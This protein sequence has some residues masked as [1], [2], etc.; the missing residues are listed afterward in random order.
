MHLYYINKS[1]QAINLAFIIL[2]CSVHLVIASNSPPII[3]PISDQVGYK[4]IEV[5]IEVEDP[6]DDIISLSV[7]SSDTDV[8]PQ[9]NLLISGVG[10]IWTLI[11][12]PAQIGHSK[13]TVYAN[14]NNGNEVST[15]FN[16]QSEPIFVMPENITALPGTFSLPLT[17]N[18]PSNE[19]IYGIEFTIDYD[20]QVINAT[21]FQL[22]ETTLIQ[23][24]LMEYN[25]GISG[26][27]I[28]CM[29]S[30]SA[31]YTGAVLIGYLHFETITENKSTSLSFSNARLN[32]W[33]GLAQTGTVTVPPNQ[34]PTI[35][36]IADV[37]TD[38][39]T[40][41]SIFFTVDDPE[42][43][44][45]SVVLTIG[46][47]NTQLAPH[48]NM[49]STCNNNNY[50]L[51]IHPANNLYGTINMTITATDSHHASDTKHFAIEVVS[52]NDPPMI[53]PI[54]NQTMIEDTVSD[55]IS[56]HI[57]DIET[58][59]SDL[60]LFASSS[61]TDVISVDNI[62]FGGA[63]ENRTLLISPS[64][65]QH[66]I[67]TIT[68]RLADSETTV[69]TD[70]SVN[71]SEIDDPPFVQNE[72]TDISVIEDSEDQIIDLSSIF[73]DI[74]NNDA[75]IEKHLLSNTNNA[76]VNAM[77][78]ENN[79]LIS[80][81]ENKSGV[82]DIEVQATSNGLTAVAFF[83]ISVTA[84]DDPPV[85]FA[86]IDDVNVDEDSQ[87]YLI[88]LSDVFSDIDNENVA[89]SKIVQHNSN[90]TLVST[91]L[92]ENA[93]T[94]SFYTNQS[95]SS[96]IT[97]EGE[98]NG[99]KITDT[100]AVTVQPVDDTPIL[101]LEIENVV[102]N[103][104]ADDTVIPLTNVFIDVD[105][106]PID[107]TIESN[108][109][110]SLVDA[111]I[112]GLKL[113][114]RY[115]NYKSG[116][117]IITIR[118]TA[119]TLFE[120]TSFIVTVISVDF[121]PELI[122]PIPDVTVNE[123][124]ENT[125]IPLTDVFSDPDNDD[126]AIEK[127]IIG[128]PNESIVI[129]TIDNN[130]LI[131]A[132]PD[133]MN[134]STRITIQ[135]ISNG[136]S[137]TDTFNIQV[138]SVDTAPRVKNPIDDI[139]IA[140]D[141]PVK[142]ILLTNVFTDIDNDD[143]LITFS[144]NQS[145]ESLLTASL[146][147][148]NLHLTFQPNQYGNSLISIQATSNGLTV[149]DAFKVLVTPVNDLPEISNLVNVSTYESM[150]VTQTFIATDP[151][152]QDLTLTM[153][154][155]DLQLL[156][157][158]N[159]IFLGGRV[160]DE[161]QWAITNDTPIKMNMTP[162]PGQTGTA[163][164]TLKITD[165]MGGDVEQFFE[166]VVRKFHIT[167]NVQGNGQIVPSGIV[168]VQK[169]TPSITFQI[170][171]E[172]DYIIDSLIVDQQAIN[173]QPT[174]TFRNVS[175]NHTI[176]AIF[177]E[178]I[179][180]TITTHLDY[181]G[182]I[183][184]NGF[185]QVKEGHSQTFEIQSQTGYRID[186]LKVNGKYVVATNEYTFNNVNES[187][188]LEI[189]FEPVPPPEADFE[190]SVN[191]GSFPLVVS[192]IDTSSHLIS[193]RTW[194][195]GDGHSKSLENP[196]HTYFEPGTY[197]VTLNVKGPGGEDTLIKSNLIEVY[198]IH[199]DYIASPAAGSYPLTVTFSAD[200]PDHVT[201]V[202]WSFGDGEN[203]SSLSP[204]H[205]YKESGE[206]ST[207]LTA[208]S[209]ST[210]VT[211]VKKGH[212]KV[213]GRNISGRVTAAD[214][215]S[216]LAGFQVEVIQQKYNHRVGETYTDDN[217]DYTFDCEPTSTNC[218]T[219]LNEI[220]AA[221]DL[222]VAV[223]PPAMN[224]D[225]YMQYYSGQSILAKGTQVSTLNNDQKKIDLVLEKALPFTIGGK[226][227]DNGIALNNTQVSAYSE[228]LSFGLNTLT[229]ENGTY[230]LSGLKASDDY[231]VY[232]WDSQ[233]NSEIYYA[234]PTQ[235]I[236]GEIIPTYS[237]YSWDAATTVDSTSGILKHIDI[238]L[239]HA[240][241]KRGF[242]QGQ[243]S[244]DSQGK[245]ENVWVYAFSE[246]L[247]FGNGAFTDE[248][249]NYTIVAL[250]EISNS[251][252]ITMGYVVAVHS[253]QYNNQDE[254]P[255]NIWYTYQAYPGVSD[256][257]K[258]QKVRTGVTGI[259]FM[260]VTQCQLTG[261]VMDIYNNPIPDAN[262]TVNSDKV[263]EDFPPAVTDE[264]GQYAFI[265]LPP[266]NDYIVI[267]TSPSYPVTYYKDH[268]ESSSADKI[269]LSYGNVGNIDFKLD[270]GMVIHGTVYLQDINTTAPEG[271]WVNIWSKST[272]TGGDV[273]T[274]M[275][276]HY[277]AVGLNPNANDYI[278]SIRIEDYMPAFY[279]DNK[280]A[281]LMND[282][283]YLPN[284]AEG[285]APSSLQWAFNR[286][287]ILRTGLTISGKILHNG[288]LVSGI[289]VEAISDNGW[290]N[291]I[292]KDSLTNDHNYKLT[293]LP[294]G[295]YIV[296]INPLYF[297][298]DSYR[299]NLTNDDVPNILFPLKELECCIC[300]TVYGLEINKHAQIVAWAEEK[301]YNHTFSL[302]G[303]GDA[304]KYTVPVKPSADYQVRFTAG[305]GYPDQ[306]YNGQKNEDVA[307][308]ISVSEGVVSGIDFNLSSGSQ[309]ISGTVHFPMSA[310]IGDIVWIDAHSPS[311][312]SNGSSEAMLVQGNQV[313]YEIT[314]LLKASDFI[315]VAWGKNF[316]EQ[317]YHHQ[318]IESSA[319]L[320]NTA[321]TIPDHAIDFDMNPGA[322]IS[323]VV[324]QNGS[325]AN[326][327]YIEAFSESASS[328]GGHTYIDNGNY[329]IEGL[330][331]AN[332]YIVKVYKTG[333]AP[334]YYHTSGSIREAKLA[335]K[336][337]TLDNKHATGIDIHTYK[338]ESISGTVRDEDGKALSDI[339]VNV[340]SYLKKCGEG[341]YTA[342]DGSYQIDGLSKSDDYIVSI[343]EHADLSYIP[344]S[345]IQVKS[346][347]SGV[348]FILRKAFHLKG[349]V[350]DTSKEPI[351]KAQ[352]ELYSDNENFD[353]WTRTDATGTFNIKCVPSANDYVLSVMP[354]DDSLSLT[355]SVSYIKFNEAG[356]SIDADHTVDYMLE[357]EIILKSGSFIAGH[358]Y[359][360]GE[361]TPIKDAEISVYS[362]SNGTESSENTTSNY[363]GYYQVNNIP[364]G[365]DYIV[366]VTTK[367]YAKTSKIDQS[368]GTTVDFFLDI[369]GSISGRVIEEEGAPL[370]EILVGIVSETASFSNSIRTD[371]N[372]NFT[373][374]GL[375]RYLDNGQEITDFIIKISP[376]NYPTQSQGQKKIGEFISFVC[377]KGGEISGLITDSQGNPIPENVVVGIKVYKKMTQGGYETKA[378][379][380]TNGQF[381]I[382]RLLFNTNYQLKVIVLESNID[383]PIQWINSS[384][385]GVSERD[386][387]GAFMAGNHVTIR[388]TGSWN[389]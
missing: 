165:G 199:I 31:I 272:Q 267:V 249:G 79:L 185:V 253:V 237:V 217:G 359:K 121:P 151:E 327:L 32:E 168:E 2:I 190:A 36:N 9:N 1:I 285:L 316:Q 368:T 315:V 73:T 304:I 105:Q 381:V 246:E 353:V 300:G 90:P 61:N 52:V 227:H 349:T 230:T 364:I 325:P 102:V 99:L 204:V 335:T 365:S 4:P 234:I 380:D 21:D 281:D 323:G 3:Q 360:S 275:Y 71:V 53:S 194:D 27:I 270:T 192:F 367:N 173:A 292:S 34:A 23:N 62:V 78:N 96:M 235:S 207:Q 148:N 119:N 320:V 123:N 273:R 87:D 278:I 22:F 386:E 57:S 261:T 131:L 291:D 280:D 50:S 109:N 326:D 132:Y 83:S 68:I 385:L 33:I 49:Y 322:S 122:H 10:A 97:I 82:A 140:E 214:N 236:P 290:D 86:S 209:G 110:E 303:T 108:T 294:P 163:I 160:I 149:V 45:C 146:E 361:Q 76:L 224:H 222:I 116:E 152:S 266:V 387:A 113:I 238:V 59:A 223:W 164:V 221:T 74:D 133:D 314:G 134:G 202:V 55:A 288:Q 242:I 15:H 274:D 296:K 369:G 193:S 145:N 38:E 92:S 14:D 324:Y 180:Y 233:Q 289:E 12:T 138:N 339:W 170:Q 107:Y 181:G 141:A 293:G 329:L 25:L 67:A 80:L 215:G 239:D 154:I 120:E 157:F 161:D 184:P 17:L 283:V 318:S 286:N 389:R 205:V 257:T 212:I 351:V 345:K 169:N 60:D 265:G 179:V 362:I 343:D 248:N 379:A 166:L 312:G 284:D 182:S 56:F 342:K 195:F 150:P 117:A 95:G 155:S 350:M 306:W 358:I 65:N 244:I 302:V 158:E 18:N 206:Y 126:L 29:A 51:V 198:D 372:G 352:V 197:T 250:N 118:G 125:I 77:I 388:L 340:W 330:D 6:E 147:Q 355:Q 84:I 297:Q 346:D 94:L 319:N 35:S 44:P 28:V 311:T 58:L 232:L 7:D 143:A 307:N 153:I 258:A 264:N 348:N 81:Q 139:T 298:D 127:I 124:A 229:D 111:T 174:Y 19:K 75:Q 191:S 186:Y 254:N 328:F 40:Q 37:T 47:D 100:F 128:Q 382:N 310:Q 115:Q 334:F 144:I 171:P 42:S 276:G 243:L 66:G 13:I 268:S 101:N 336:V 136:K 43:S 370:A 93:L 333:M 196:K 210:N 8:I 371:I 104:N 41:T 301:G 252:P 226:V 48:E 341:I 103:E 363:E 259:D 347:S 159:I 354:Y 175:E 366:T 89:I 114:L 295:E 156:P 72:I 218:L 106:D 247:D 220:P 5:I 162:A 208:Y 178:P 331:L 201:R 187:H 216:G 279:R 20:P 172:N 176:T 54:E 282:T 251:D 200:M 39:D 225:Y 228:K 277:Q 262:V 271:F 69:S 85:V 240:T 309:V 313:N 16:F 203:S 383:H 241:N 321:D 337:N 378:A 377:K 245:A 317:Y 142:T 98:S 231:R 167:A 88:D 384:G 375:P 305:N 183:R 332:D 256:K 338:L 357:K 374:S 11:I 219:V 70:F 308:I 269:D 64:K 130:R 344:D 263:G 177:R 287:L 376:E 91:S 24:Y 30:N 26:Q 373:F 260:L 255:S 188:N 299:V 189:F 213:K 211:V 112:V 63:G 356:L 46:I 137:V 129:A 135:G